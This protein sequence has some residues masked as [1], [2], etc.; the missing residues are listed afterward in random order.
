MPTPELVL[1]HRDQHEDPT[2]QAQHDIQQEGFSE[3]A[4][5]RRISHYHA[6]LGMRDGVFQKDFPAL[7][8]A[9]QEGSGA[10]SVTTSSS[11]LGCVLEYEK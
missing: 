10:S 5:D 6:T 8:L 2:I 7:K 11:H 1:A 3:Y 4:F 9:E